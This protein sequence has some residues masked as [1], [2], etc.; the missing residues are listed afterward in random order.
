MKSHYRWD[1]ATNPA[2]VDLLL[3]LCDKYSLRP[4]FALPKRNPE[5]TMRRVAD[6]QVHVLREDMEAVAM[7]TLSPF[8]T[9]QLPQNVVLPCANNPLYISRLAVAPRLQNEG[10][11]VGAQCLKQAT[12]IAKNMGA[13]AIRSEANPA[14]YRVV[15]L[16]Y[17]FE[18][19][20]FFSSSDDSSGLRIYLQK[21]LD[22]I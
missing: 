14:I 10:S 3:C 16:L 21:T 2:E 17:L 4:G 19:Q 1:V 7:F 12:N 6:R 22:D 11:I 8:P 18:F 20:V 15:E 9:F 13:D 5:T